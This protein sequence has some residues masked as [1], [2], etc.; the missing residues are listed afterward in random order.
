MFLWKE[1]VKK[2]RWDIVLELLQLMAA[3][4]LLDEPFDVLVSRVLTQLLAQLTHSS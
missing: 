3:K 4:Q 2:S 1:S